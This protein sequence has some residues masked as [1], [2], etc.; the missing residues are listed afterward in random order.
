MKDGKNKATAKGVGRV[1][2]RGMTHQDYV[3]RYEN[4]NM[5]IKEVK[6]MQ[7]FNHVIFNV[8]HKKIALLFT[9]NKRA[10]VDDNYSLSY[11]H[12]KLADI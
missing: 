11:G 8:V 12:Y 5:L 2:A 4:K 3:D 6:R 7:S 10:W 9:E 1:V